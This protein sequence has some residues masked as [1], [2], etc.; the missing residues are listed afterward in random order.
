MG[1]DGEAYD[2]GKSLTFY[3]VA[4]KTEENKNMKIECESVEK[5]CTNAD[6]TY[7]GSSVSDVDA[8]AHLECKIID[9]TNTDEIPCIDDNGYEV[10][11]GSTRVRYL[12]DRITVDADCVHIEEYCN[13]E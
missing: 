13:A 7:Q 1:P 5:T 11:A 4:E 3:K 10:P 2:D 6:F 8:Y 9:R 12:Q